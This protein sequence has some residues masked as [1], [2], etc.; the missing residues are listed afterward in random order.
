MSYTR[1]N[2]TLL[3]NKIFKDGNLSANEFRVLAYLISKYNTKKGYSYPTRKQIK[4]DMGIS[5]NTLNNVLNSLE[6]KGYITREK[7]KNEKNLWNN[8]YYIH[9]SK[10][11][12]IEFM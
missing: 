12:H 9:K 10:M 11:K 2:Y 6:K 5:E 7:R 8:I 1:I 3:D 4:D